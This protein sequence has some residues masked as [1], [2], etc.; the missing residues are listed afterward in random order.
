M[1][2]FYYPFFDTSA[3]RTRVLLIT[4]T[5]MTTLKILRGMES[6]DADDLRKQLATWG[7][8][9]SSRNFPEPLYKLSTP[10]KTEKIISTHLEVLFDIYNI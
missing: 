10:P 2:T 5:T 3:S 8:Y 9:Y 7:E 6:Q 1:I 4:G